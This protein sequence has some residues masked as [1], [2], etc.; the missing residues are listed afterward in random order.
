[1]A[2]NYAMNFTCLNH[3]VTPQFAWYPHSSTLCH[4]PPTVQ[5]LCHLHRRINS[6]LK[7]IS[8]LKLLL[9]EGV[10]KKNQVIFTPLSNILPSLTRT[11][12]YFLQSEIIFPLQ[13]VYFNYYFVASSSQ[14]VY[15]LT[16]FTHV[17]S[18]LFVSLLSPLLQISPVLPLITSGAYITGANR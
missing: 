6:W 17:S 3:L 2:S 13:S 18:R 14:R 1:M 8:S 4:S 10:V 12:F 9:R 11:N 16:L 15:S 5:L 7:F